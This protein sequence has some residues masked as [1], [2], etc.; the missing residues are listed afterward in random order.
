MVGRVRRMNGWV[1]KGETVFC[2]LV[3]RSDWGYVRSMGFVEVDRHVE[4]QNNQGKASLAKTWASY[5]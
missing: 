4:Y 5:I 2:F 3:D 1:L